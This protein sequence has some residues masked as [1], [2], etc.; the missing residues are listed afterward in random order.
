MSTVVVRSISDSSRPTA[1]QCSRRI[2][3]RSASFVEAA[4][5]VPLV[6]VLR[7]RPERLLGPAAADHD[8]QARLHRPRGHQRILHRVHGAVVRD[9]LPVQQPAQ[10]HRGLVEAVQ[11]LAEPGPE[12]D[13]ERLVLALEPGAAEAEDGAPAG[14][15]VERRGELRREA[16]VA[17][18]VGRD[19]QAQRGPARDLRPAREDGPALEDRPLPRPDDRV[20]V[21][22]GPEARGARSLGA[23]GRV[24]DGR[25]G[26]GLGPEQE[27]DLDVGH[28]VSP[29]GGR[30]C[31]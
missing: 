29:P 3:S 4:H 2:A 28:R 26:V 13:A 24:A 21:V 18:R 12:V 14:E 8:R 27:P 9:E 19:H 17:E 7:Q 31:R 5:R 1:A 16:R 6:A 30:G 23:H 25:P 11:P 15:M 20:E 10:E 22:P